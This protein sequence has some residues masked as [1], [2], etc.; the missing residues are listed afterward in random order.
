[1]L[2]TKKPHFKYNYLKGSWNSYSLSAQTSG[3]RKTRGEREHYITIKESSHLE[4]KI[5]LN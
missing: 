1:M 4:D 5:I 3:G 2:S